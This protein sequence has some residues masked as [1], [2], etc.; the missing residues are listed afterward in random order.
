MVI[1]YNTF[2]TKVSCDS[3][4]PYFDIYMGGLQP[5]R[6]YRILIKSTINGSTVVI[7]DNNIFKVVR[8]V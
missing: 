2:G 5:E 6:Y 1:D 7:D 3:S 4:G 8:N